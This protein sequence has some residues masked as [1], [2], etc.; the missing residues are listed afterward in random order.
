MSTSWTATGP[1]CRSPPTAPPCSPAATAS[2]SPTLAGVLSPVLDGRAAVLARVADAWCASN[3]QDVVEVLGEVV[4]V[5]DHGGR[6]GIVGLTGRVRRGP[7]P[8]RWSPDSAAMPQRD[9]VR[10]DHDTSVV[11]CVDPEALLLAH[12]AG[13]WEL[14]ARP[15]N[16]YCRWSDRSG[17]QARHLRIAHGTLHEGSRRSSAFGCRACGLAASGDTGG[18]G[19]RSC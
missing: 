16:G 4:H 7:H 18:A 9:T 3:E 14:V 15:V 5:A 8:G 1:A 2:N 12:V 10:D 19:G 17:R 13:S 11:G 6:P